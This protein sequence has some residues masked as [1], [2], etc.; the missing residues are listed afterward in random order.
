MR[1]RGVRVAELAVELERP[2]GRG[3]RPAE[4]FLRGNHA[5]AGQHDVGIRDAGVGGR[6]VRTALQHGLELRDAP[7]HRGLGALVQVVPPFQQCLEC[8]RRQVAHGIDP[9]HAARCELDPDAGRYR[10]RDFGLESQHVA[11]GALVVAGPGL[12]LVGNLDQARRDAYAP[13]RAA[14]GALEHV[15][16]AEFAADV[17]DAPARSLEHQAGGPGDHAE[18]LRVQGRELGD[19]L[20]GQAVG[21]EIVPATAACIRERQ[22]CEHHALA[23]GCVGCARVERRDESIAALRYRRDVGAARVV[24][25]ER[26][27][28]D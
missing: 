6:A 18:P 7:P 3:R 17:R 10:L 13:A 5:A 12:R 20:L 23:S 8:V 4:C 2:A 1:E 22:H 25:A 19:H 15:M 28:Q 21:E 27:A 11:G 9:A 24:A 16:H 14:H 26:L